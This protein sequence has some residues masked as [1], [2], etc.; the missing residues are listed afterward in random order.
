[1]MNDKVKKIA[2]ELIPYII[3][4][5]VVVLIRSYIVTPVM[6]SGTSMSPTLKGREIMILNKLDKKYSRFEIVVLKTDHDDII[7]RVIGLPGETISCENNKIY[8]N[9]RKIDDKYGNGTTAD[10]K[11]VTL[12]KDEYFVLGDNRENSLDSRYYGPFKK[13]KIK[14]STKLVVFP[15][16]KIGTVE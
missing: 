4:L 5:L 2:K 6:V 8:V 1:M 3:I 7:K 15:F 13:E 16:S 10:F 11:K 9:S 14:G 12:G